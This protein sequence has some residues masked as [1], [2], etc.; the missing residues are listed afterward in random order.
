MTRDNPLA[1]VIL[2][3][4]KGS[5]MKS[6]KPKVMHELAGLPMINWL[7]SSVE[8]LEPEKI[9]VV[10][11]EGMDDVVDAVKPHQIAIQKNQSGTG[12]AVKSALPYL[13]GFKGDVLVL[14]GDAPLISPETMEDLI[15]TKNF[16]AISGLSVLGIELEDPTGYGRLIADDDGQLVG[17]VEHKDCTEEQLACNVINTG[18]FCVS[19]EKLPAWLE[20]LSSD[21]AQGEYYFTDIPA[22]ALEDGYKTEVCITE[23]GMEVQGVNTR[24]QLAELEA[25]L[26][27][28]LKEMVMEGGVT[29]LSPDTVYLS[30]DLEIG[31]DVIIEPNVYIGKGV[32]IGNNVRIKAFSH[33]ED[34]VI[35]GESDIGPY[36]RLRPGAH[37]SKKARIGNFVEVKN[38]YIGEGS[39]ANHLAYIGDAQ[40]GSGSNIGAGTITC[41]YDGFKKHKTQI[42]DNVFVGS[43]ST[44]VA[45]VNLKDGSFVAAGS[46]IAEDVP[47]DT[48][49]VARNRPIMRD[50]WA[51][52]FR[53]KQSN[54]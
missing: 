49:A 24:I 32:K 28:R 6:N 33:L 45:P 50:G 17:I 15:E 53:N 43:N 9:I 12:D 16:E 46:T 42:G 5:R 19:G 18:A 14:L 37:I 40:I 1:V 13:K 2:A 47:E 41:N 48:L 20:K 44:L 36:A 7:I 35:E 4:G 29:L 54:S 34:C 27:D 38:S 26:Q 30:C 52:D 31:Q 11:A 25:E 10:T 39:K 21:N 3:A 22:I 23:D 8:T 51:K